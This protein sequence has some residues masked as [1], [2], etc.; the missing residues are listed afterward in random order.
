MSLG[1]EWAGIRILAAVEADCHAAQTFAIN[2]P[3][4]NVINRQIEDVQPE[5]AWAAQRPL[6]ILG[7]P[8]CQGFST[9]NQR[10]RSSNNPLNW[11][12]RQYFRFAEELRPDWIVFENVPGILVTAGGQF[13]KAVLAEFLRLGY[14][15]QHF[16]LN[17]ADYGV[18]QRRSRLFVVASLKKNSLVPPKTKVASHGKR[19]NRR[20]PD[21]Q[22]R[23]DARRVAL[24]LFSQVS[25]CPDT[26]RSAQQ[27][28][29]SFGD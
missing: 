3:H 17:A 13:L 25:I 21:S 4:T 5:S 23:L 12:F 9:S 11:L 28:P 2:H 7:G 20:S 10:T 6:A 24:S 19:R 26:T 14:H 27:M 16:I 8:P 22:K 1:A 15:T 18:P 29:K